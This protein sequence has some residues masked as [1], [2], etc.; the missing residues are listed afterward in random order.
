M[1]FRKRI[2]GSL[3]RLS[4]SWSLPTLASTTKSRST[5]SEVIEGAFH[6]DNMYADGDQDPTTLRVMRHFYHA[7]D[8]AGLTW[9]ENGES[10]SHLGKIVAAWSGCSSCAWIDS[11]Q[12]RQAGVCASTRAFRA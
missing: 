4:N 6:E 8:Q 9:S 10:P 12:E 5:S 7:P 1:T 11:G 3:V 2:A